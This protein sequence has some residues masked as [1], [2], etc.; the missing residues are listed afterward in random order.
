MQH[1]RG[2]KRMIAGGDEQGNRP[3]CAGSRQAHERAALSADGTKLNFARQRT[4]STSPASSSLS[5]ET[6]IDRNVG[7]R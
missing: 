6:L 3:L 1:L 2:Q 7:A 4:Q 5:I